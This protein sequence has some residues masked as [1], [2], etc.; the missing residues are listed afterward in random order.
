MLRFFH[1]GLG[2]FQKGLRF[3]SSVQVVSVMVK[4]FS[5]KGR[6]KDFSVRLRFF[7]NGFQIVS[8]DVDMFSEVSEIFSGGVGI[9]SVVLKLNLFG[10]IKIFIFLGEG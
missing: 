8:G 6:G 5:G 10:R 1:R 4:L 7:R 2:F 9:F 3:S